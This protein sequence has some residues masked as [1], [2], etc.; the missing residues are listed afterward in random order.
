MYQSHFVRT[1]LHKKK[2]YAEL[3]AVRTAIVC[4]RAFYHA[5]IYIKFGFDLENYYFKFRLGDINSEDLI[6]VCAS[7]YTFPKFLYAI[8]PEKIRSRF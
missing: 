3:G 7:K 6:F 5:N 8:R 2:M 4:R 1:T